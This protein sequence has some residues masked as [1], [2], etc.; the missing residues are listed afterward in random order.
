MKFSK[1]DFQK[2]FNE[3]PFLGSAITGLTNTINEANE[4]QRNMFGFEGGKGASTSSDFRESEQNLKNIAASMI[5]GGFSTGTQLYQMRVSF[6]FSFV[7][8][9]ALQT[10]ASS[11][12][13]YYQT[14]MQA[15]YY[16]E[17]LQFQYEVMGVQSMSNILNSIIVPLVVRSITSNKSLS[18][19]SLLVRPLLNRVLPSAVRGVGGAAALS[20][21]RTAAR[22]IRSQ[23]T[24]RLTRGGAGRVAA[25][26]APVA[27]QALL[28]F[29]AVSLLSLA[30]QISKQ[31]QDARITEELAETK[32]LSN[33]FN[34]NEALSVFQEYSYL[35]PNQIDSGDESGLSSLVNTAFEDELANEN[36]RIDNIEQRRYSIASEIYHSAMENLSMDVRSFGFTNKDVLSVY[37][38]LTRTTQVST[39]LDDVSAEILLNSGLYTGGNVSQMSQIMSTII[40]AGGYTEDDINEAA[41][42]FEEF[43]A[44]VVGDGDP[45]A[46]HL[47]LVSSLASFAYS[48]GAGRRMNLN[49]SEEIAK[50]Q[51]FM[52]ENGAINDRFTSAPTQ[53]AV[54]TIDDLLLK[55]AMGTDVASMRLFDFINVDRE[56]AIRGVTND[57]EVF[58]RSLV[59]ILSFLGVSK[60]DAANQTEG[61]YR[62]LQNFSVMMGMNREEIN[63]L[64]VAL[65][66][67]GE[68]ERVS[69]I[70]ENYL[71][72]LENE[73]NSDVSATKNLSDS[74]VSFY[75]TI[76]NITYSANKN[77]DVITQNLDFAVESQLAIENMVSKNYGVFIDSFVGII[78]IIA[79]ITEL[80]E[81]NVSRRSREATDVISGLGIESINGGA[82]YEEERNFIRNQRADLTYAPSVLE[83][84]E[85]ENFTFDEISKRLSDE[86]LV[87]FN[88]VVRIMES[89]D[90]Y[91]DVGY[92]VT[93]EFI[94][95]FRVV[96][97]ENKEEILD[98]F[99]FSGDTNFKFFDEDSNESEKEDLGA[100]DEDSVPEV[101]P[102]V[103]PISSPVF[104]DMNDTDDSVPSDERG[105][106]SP[107]YAGLGRDTR[108]PVVGVNQND[109]PVQSDEH[110]DSVFSEVNNSSAYAINNNKNNN[111]AITNNNNNDRV[112]EKNKIN[113][114]NS[115]NENQK[116]KRTM[117]LSI[118]TISN[119]PSNLARRFAE[120]FYSQI[121]LNKD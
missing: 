74:M 83:D 117:V 24:R 54:K 52:S 23:I 10:A 51:Q 16:R 25:R 120:E 18:E 30:F 66:K 48:Y 12:G 7:R 47:N 101:V 53:S 87:Y 37:G 91:G 50:I 28:I 35:I 105:S 43:F 17:Q 39:G 107:P 5:S 67:Y 75:E 64:S 22:N 93:P 59:G 108:D 38:D 88:E 80:N 86:Q 63:V 111:Y 106:S 36:N 60:E 8:S 13:G 57:A 62:A 102:F 1:E 49:A 27:G 55:G 26:F 11:L 19:T 121:S 118:P 65:Q 85:G 77:V 113:F 82:G 42:R 46:A 2:R 70:R 21:V 89:S 76:R 71:D 45:Q 109:V 56:E 33:F 116:T 112:D 44:V 115:T 84:L 103:D 29:E 110:S 69:R 4:K 98:K 73:I 40:R 100:N 81:S 41:N 104:P 79:G 58:E 119:N 72:N 3:D 31:L 114:G 14:L 6:D 97:R 68:G 92:E 9:H 20:A 32:A 96:S 15:V 90:V 61:F 34:P 99:G 95:N 78:D 94:N